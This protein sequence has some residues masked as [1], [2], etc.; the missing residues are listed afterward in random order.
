M[1]GLLLFGLALLVAAWLWSG[2]WD[3]DE[4]YRPFVWRDVALV[5]LACAVPLVA[6]LVVLVRRRA[7]DWAWVGFGLVCLV[8][9]PW[10]Y[11]AARCRHD[12]AEVGNL[13][14]QSRLGEARTLAHRVVALDP[15]ASWNEQP[16]ARLAADLDRRVAELEAAIADPATAPLDRAG[17]RAMLGRTGEALAELEPVAGPEANILRGLIHETRGDWPAGLDAYRAARTALEARPASG[18]RDAGLAQ[19]LR[20][21]AY[22]LRKQGDYAAA[23]AAY[24]DLLKLAPTAETHFLIARFY[25]DAQYAEKAHH[26]ARQAI[27]LDPRRYRER[28]ATLIDKLATHHFGCLQV[29]T[30]EASRSRLNVLGR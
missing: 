4:P 25:E 24:H 6:A 16:L 26:H 7:V 9:P 11:V 2:V 20:G 1:A 8:V 17:A 10:L 13:L 23:E 22:C 12:V 27:A 15:L 3:A 14:D 21:I 18:E 5:W 30:A 19:A 28:G 29:F